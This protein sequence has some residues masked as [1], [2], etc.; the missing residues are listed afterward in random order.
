MV[1]PP[2]L[3]AIDHDDYHAE[4]IG[5]TEDNRQFILTT[6]FDPK[7]SDTH[8]G[9]EFVALYKFDLKG[10]LLEAKI[11]NFGPRKSVDACAHQAACERLLKSLG[12]VSFERV[13]VAPFAVD[14]F[15]LKFGLVV[16]EPDDEDDEWAVEM[17]PGNYMAFFSPWD[18]GDY[19]T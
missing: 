15:G 7:M 9:S 3:I 1:E 6:P 18:S 10:C 13:E 5:R 14:R 17:Q 4:Y 19:D 8:P 12:N 11:E 16:R 2:T